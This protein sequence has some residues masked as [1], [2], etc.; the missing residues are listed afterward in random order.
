[1]L[2]GFG[3]P[4]LLIIAVL[5]I[6][7]FGAKRLPDAAR[8]LGK[9]MRI[10]KA[11]TRGMQDEEA[12]ASSGTTPAQPQQIAAPQQPTSAPFATP[13]PAEQANGQVDQ[14]R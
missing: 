6:V 4:H 8:G 11:E 7:L 13:T 1:M 12:A 2:N 10:F 5:I 3:W 9:S 14:Q